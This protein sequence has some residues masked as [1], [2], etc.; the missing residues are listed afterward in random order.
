MG[1]IL[2]MPLQTA[3]CLLAEVGAS[4]PGLVPA[5]M[6]YVQREERKARRHV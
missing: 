6:T 4:S 2:D 3:W 1:D 5:G